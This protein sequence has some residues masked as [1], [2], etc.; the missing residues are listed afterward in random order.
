[1]SEMIELFSQ[2][3]VKTKLFVLA[4]ISFGLILSIFLIG[5]QQIN[6]LG[7]E[8]DKLVKFKF[9]LHNKLEHIQFEHSMQ[10]LHLQELTHF[11]VGDE[12]FDNKKVEI[13]VLK[14]SINEQ[15]DEAFV[16]IA[17][18]DSNQLSDKVYESIKDL[19]FDLRTVEKAS[20]GFQFDLKR[21]IHLFEQEKVNKHEDFIQEINEAQ[22]ELILTLSTFR[23]KME[24]YFSLFRTE[25]ESQ[26]EVAIALMMIFS[27]LIAF[28][29]FGVIA[30]INRSLQDGFDQVLSNL[31]LLKKG[32][33]KIEFEKLPQNELGEILKTLSEMSSA[34]KESENSLLDQI[35]LAQM[36]AKTKG[37]FV[38]T[39]SHEIR[40]PLN[41]VMGMI[42]LMK[43]TALS[44][45]QMSYIETLERSGAH[46]LAIVNDILDFS[47]LEEGKVELMLAPFQIRDL[48][49]EVVNYFSTKAAGKSIAIDFQMDAQL[50]LYYLG[51]RRH[52]KHIMDHLL[53]NAIKFTNVG[54]VTLAV[55]CGR[56]GIL[57]FGVEDTG[58]GIPESVGD[59][60]F[61]SFYQGDMS[62]TR[63]F[64]GTGLGL[65]ICKR[66]VDLMGGE[67]GY[68]STIGKGTKFWFEVPLEPFQLESNSAE[69]S[70]LITP[71][72]AKVLIVDAHLNEIKSMT[73]ALSNLGFSCESVHEGEEALLAMA[74]NHFDLVLLDMQLSGLN[75]FEIAERI[76]Q[77]ESRKFPILAMSTHVSSHDRELAYK[78][79]MDDFVLKSVDQKELKNS[80]KRFFKIDE[81]T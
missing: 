39:M 7:E 70:G 74:E 9:P 60:L 65:A 10:F 28:T 52:L 57:R 23:E 17:K 1:M 8:M 19:E 4:L 45:E 21:F 79:G 64:G 72:E 15:F 67:I 46:L 38:S 26:K 35:E 77:N 54:S 63:E 5:V 31:R 16:L 2:F 58:M 37:E 14:K 3:K 68:R 56:N 6:S 25:A 32:H 43:S 62:N 20:A 44:E 34:L 48:I 24:V 11:K 76:R 12:S 59:K 27:G 36:A 61:N 53:S 75:G 78:V 42:E 41:G 81:N 71:K 66:L 40:T 80:L 55:E 30:M 50:S 33:R 69:E 13:E 22:D 18:S 49:R 51:D 47:K 73:T 29:G